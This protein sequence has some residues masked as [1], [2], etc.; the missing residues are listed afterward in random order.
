MTF[1]LTTF[2]AIVAA[3]V[4][5]LVYL[6]FRMQ[7]E[8]M[9]FNEELQFFLKHRIMSENRAKA[10]VAVFKTRFEKLEKEFQEMA[11]ENSSLKAHIK[12]FDSSN[13]KLELEITSIQEALSGSNIKNHL[14]RYIEEVDGLNARLNKAK[15][16]V[17]AVRINSSL[18]NLDIKDVA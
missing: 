1:T 4:V 11:E 12:S 3:A 14:V 5:G 17:T 10:Q 13:E 15:E 18:E 16:E 7:R 8:A 6:A 2:V 9:K